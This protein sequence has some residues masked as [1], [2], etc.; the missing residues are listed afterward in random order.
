LPAQTPV[1]FSSTIPPTTEFD[2]VYA[3]GAYQNFPTV[4]GRYFFGV[5]GEYIFNLTASA[6]DT[7]AL[8]PERVAVLRDSR[9]FGR[10]RCFIGF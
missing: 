8:A 2:S 5:R 6:L 10:T 1:D 9:R 7:R 4:G 3:T